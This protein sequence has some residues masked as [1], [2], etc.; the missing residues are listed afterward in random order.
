MISTHAKCLMTSAAFGHTVI[1][2]KSKGHEKRASTID[3]RA[4]FDPDAEV[5]WL[6]MGTLVWITYPGSA[7]A[8]RA[9]RVIADSGGDKVTVEWRADTSG[10]RGGIK[11]RTRGTKHTES[12][13]WDRLRPRS[14]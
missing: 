10:R 14:R 6:E 9:A 1:C 2:H 11:T 3:H 12:I 4:H 13:P 5:S 7:K 8:D